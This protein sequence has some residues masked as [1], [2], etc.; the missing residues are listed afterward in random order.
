MPSVQTVLDAIRPLAEFYRVNN[1]KV[2]RI[3]VDPLMW[4]RVE[5]MADDPKEPRIIRHMDGYPMYGAYELYRI[6]KP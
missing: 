3:A 2:E 6:E 1:R 4:R 5:A